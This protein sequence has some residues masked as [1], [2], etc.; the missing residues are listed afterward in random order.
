MRDLLMDISSIEFWLNVLEQLRS[1][2]L[3]APLCLACLESF[4]PVLPLLAIITFNLAVYGIVKGTI[5]S[6]I[7]TTLGNLL[8]FVIVRKIIK[9]IF[10]KTKKSTQISKK[11]I[12]VLNEFNVFLIYCCPFAPGNLFNVIL[13]FS[14]FKI[15][16]FFKL[17][18]VAKII[19][20]FIIVFFNVMGYRFSN[21]WQGWI[22]IGIMLAIFLLI[23]RN[24]DFQFKIK[25]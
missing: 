24:F 13:G 3:L 21:S 10:L 1:F 20:I 12:P 22:F 16:S 5:A 23:K 15:S 19:F 25:E 6:W 11:R 9:P 2:G 7:G 8:V 4:F 14:D 17:I 18:P